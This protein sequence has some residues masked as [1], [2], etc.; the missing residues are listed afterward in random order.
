MEKNFIRRSGLCRQ[1][2]S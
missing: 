2:C 1:L